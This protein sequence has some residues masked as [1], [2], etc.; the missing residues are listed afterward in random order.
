MELRLDS[1]SS[2]TLQWRCRQITRVAHSII[3]ASSRIDNLWSLVV[4]DLS[5]QWGRDSIFVVFVSAIFKFFYLK[6]SRETRARQ[7]NRDDCQD[8]VRFHFDLSRYLII[9]YWHWRRTRPNISRFRMAETY[10]LLH[11]TGVAP[12][13]ALRDA[14]VPR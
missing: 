3:L 2:K 14:T 7:Y 1:G 8:S 11:H 13:R 5:F 10:K 9:T 12:D 4:E 6:Y